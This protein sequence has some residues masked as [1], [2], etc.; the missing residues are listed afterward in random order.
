MKGTLAE[1]VGNIESR[2][3]ISQVKQLIDDKAFTA[4]DN[5]SQRGSSTPGANNVERDM[6]ALRQ[7]LDETLK[8]VQK[9]EAPMSLQEIEERL[10]EKANKQ[11]VAQ[12]LHRKANKAEVEEAI[13]KKV[14]FDDLLK[15]LADKADMQHIQSI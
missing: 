8:F 9:M 11:S 7:K 12:A 1:I 5:R 4:Q 3:T 13:A 2:A 6:L 15:A 10:S 14:D